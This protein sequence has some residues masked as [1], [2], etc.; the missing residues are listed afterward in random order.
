M[1]L[2]GRRYDILH[3]LIYSSDQNSDEMAGV[4]ATILDYEEKVFI[5]AETWKKPGFQAWI[6]LLWAN[7]REE[8]NIFPILFYQ[9]FLRSL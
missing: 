8:M 3:S 1:F 5:K 9:L 2:K 6:P 4:L 7:L